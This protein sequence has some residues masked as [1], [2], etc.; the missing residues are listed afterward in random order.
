MGS[1]EGSREMGNGRSRKLGIM[2][3]L[4]LG[5]GALS[6]AEAAGRGAAPIRLQAAC[7]FGQVPCSCDGVTFVCLSPAVCRRIVCGS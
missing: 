5:I 1:S 4:A 3:V 6:S 2:L 7:G